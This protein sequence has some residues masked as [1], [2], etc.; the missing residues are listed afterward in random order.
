M[1][2]HATS[3]RSREIDVIRE[4]C[5]TAQV[6]TTVSLALLEELDRTRGSL[7]R[8]TYLA[9]IIDAAITLQA[10]HLPDVAESAD[11]IDALAER[12]YGQHVRSIELSRQAGGS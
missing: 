9:Q 11:L 7:P 5:P 10:P 4:Q 12:R 6:T 1:T 2:R 8:S 3:T